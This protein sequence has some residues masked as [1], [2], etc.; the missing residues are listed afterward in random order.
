[1]DKIKQNRGIEDGRLKPNVIDS[2]SFHP[3]VKEALKN[4]RYSDSFGRFEEIL[5][6][7]IFNIVGNHGIKI[8]SNMYASSNGS[9]SRLEKLAEMLNRK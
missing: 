7:A 1:L 9:A 3:Y 2:M 5:S 8:I 6:A 4:L